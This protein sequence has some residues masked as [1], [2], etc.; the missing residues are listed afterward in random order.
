LP[1]L[2]SDFA[3]EALVLPLTSISPVETAVSWSKIQFL[4]FILLGPLFLIEGL[5]S[6]SLTLPYLLSSH[7]LSSFDLN[8]L[9]TIAPL[10]SAAVLIGL[11]LWLLGKSGRNMAR[12]SFHLPEPHDAFFAFLLPIGLSVLL[13]RRTTLSTARIGLFM[14]STKHLPLHSAPISI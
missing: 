5:A 13:P 1:F 12:S 10:L 8:V 11:A 4:I 7:P 9:R 6:F 3:L 14:P 2:L